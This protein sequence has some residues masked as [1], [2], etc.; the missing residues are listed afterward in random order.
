MS[1][2]WGITKA[3]IAVEG[4]AMHNKLYDEWYEAY[5]DSEYEDFMTFQHYVQRKYPAVY[6]KALA[7]GRVAGLV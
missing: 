1:A 6:K 5:I 2:L 4:T 7:Y 3:I